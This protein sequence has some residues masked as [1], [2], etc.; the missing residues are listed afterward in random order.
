MIFHLR[1][2]YH[3]VYDW[4]GAVRSV[5][6]VIFIL[7]SVGAAATAASSCTFISTTAGWITYYPSNACKLNER[8]TTISQLCAHTTALRR[9]SLG[10]CIVDKVVCSCCLWLL[11]YTPMRGNVLRHSGAYERTQTLC[12][13]LH[14]YHQ[15][16][17]TKAHDTSTTIQKEKQQTLCE[18]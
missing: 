14:H 13:V 4:N 11:T 2:C 18:K 12:R 17:R 15:N 8:M 7:Y 16:Q 1:L 10:I 9:H 3:S 5:C 6:V